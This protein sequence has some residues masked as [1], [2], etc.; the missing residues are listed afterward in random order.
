ME[1]VGKGHVVAPN[2]G[3]LSR[4]VGCVS[5]LHHKPANIPMKYRSVVL[6]RR[7]QCEKVKGGSRAGIAKDLAFQIPVRRVNSNRHNALY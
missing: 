1:F 6:A 2:R 7:R 4:D 5:P 3:F